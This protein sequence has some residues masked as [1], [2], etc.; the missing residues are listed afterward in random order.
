MV[1]VGV[2]RRDIV[3]VVLPTKELPQQQQAGD[4]HGLNSDTSD[5]FEP[6]PPASS[7]ATASSSSV[8]AVSSAQQSSTNIHLQTAVNHRTLLSLALS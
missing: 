6:L 4:C 5:Q 8:L 2:G 3:S 1:L 7:A